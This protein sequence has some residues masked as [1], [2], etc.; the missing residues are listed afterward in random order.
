MSI[1]DASANCSLTTHLLTLYV[2]VERFQGR[3]KITHHYL[4]SQSQLLLKQSESI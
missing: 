2:V 3:K 4:V 1:L